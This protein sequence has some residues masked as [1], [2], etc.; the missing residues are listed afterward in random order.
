MGTVTKRV[1]DEFEGRRGTVTSDSSLS[2]ETD[3]GN[4][5]QGLHQVTEKISEEADAHGGGLAEKAKAALRHADRELGGEYERREDPDA[6]PSPQA[7]DPE[8]L[9]T[10]PQRE[11]A[12]SADRTE[13]RR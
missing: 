8:Q 1:D 5:A 3:P 11:A 7:V 10:G 6:V 13:G 2:E 9:P 4:K 12:R